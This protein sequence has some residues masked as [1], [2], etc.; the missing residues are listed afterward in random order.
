MPG[1]KGVTN[2][3]GLVLNT[4]VERSGVTK[5]EGLAKPAGGMLARPGLALTADERG[6]GSWDAALL[7][8]NELTGRLGL[9]GDPDMTPLGVCMF[10]NNGDLNGLGR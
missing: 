4:P 5:D 2:G 10:L 1:L 9:R 7:K 3:A 6:W 8:V